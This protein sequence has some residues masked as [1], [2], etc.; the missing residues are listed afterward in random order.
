MGFLIRDT[1][2]VIR[3]APGQKVVK[4]SDMDAYCD[5]ERLLAEARKRAEDLIKDARTAYDEERKRG[6]KEGQNEARM[7]AAEQMIEIV[8]RSIDY[9]G[10]VE[11]RMVDLVMTALRKILAE[12]DDRD[13]V[14]QV[15][16]HALSTV[17]NQKQVTL[18]LPPDQAE[19]LR[20]RVNELL[21]A[22][23]AIGFLDITP[24]SRLSADNCIIE[25]DIGSVE[26][27]IEVQLEAIRRAFEKSF[28]SRHG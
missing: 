13:R 25:S 14:V 7:E 9:F 17:R 15:V 24:D 6:Y 19:L 4:A 22:Y 20:D 3:L 28:G 27:G 23:P 10:S 18:R 12:Y 1:E 11:T 2:H 8:S 16:K 21:A 26:A 5:A